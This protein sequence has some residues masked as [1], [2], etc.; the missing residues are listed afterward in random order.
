M[1]VGRSTFLW[2]AAAAALLMAGAAHANFQWRFSSGDTATAQDASTDPPKE[3]TVTATA[4]SNTSGPGNNLLERAYL[5]SYSGGLGVTNYD[6]PD[7]DGREG[8]YPE[9]AIDNDDRFD[10]VL[11]DFGGELI[12]LETITVGWK[13]W[14]G[15][16]DISLLAYHPAAGSGMPVTPNLS[17]MSYSGTSQGLTTGGWTLVGSYDVDSSGWSPADRGYTA[18]VNRTNPVSSSYWLVSA[19]NPIF[20]SAGCSP[21]GKC[22][23]GNDYFKILALAGVQ[24][25]PEEGPSPP[26]GVPEPSGVLLLVGGLA[27]LRGVRVRRAQG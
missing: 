2:V 21:A 12:T 7:D 15:D 17:G 1:N 22:G 27:L 25:T 5:R 14:Y 13:Y 8:S 9:H 19:Y 24:P 20:G 18:S 16:A 23:S 11:F 10:L 6:A 26:T 4:W 3:I